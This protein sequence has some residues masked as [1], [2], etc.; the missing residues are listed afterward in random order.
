MNAEFADMLLVYR[1]A[2]LGGQTAQH[3]YAEQY[4]MRHTPSHKLFS[5]LYQR[6]AYMVS[7][8]RAVIVKNMQTM[9][10]MTGHT[11][12]YNYTLI[13]QLYPLL[14]YLDVLLLFIRS[15]SFPSF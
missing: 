15:R 2:E 6:L 14:I 11:Y 10:L 7:F 12:N 1:A 8:Q 5:H 9:D 13:M 4:P 3:L